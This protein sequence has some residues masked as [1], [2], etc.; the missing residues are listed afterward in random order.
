MRND[1]AADAL[2]PRRRS[3]RRSARD[4]K[5]IDVK[6]VPAS[7]PVDDNETDTVVI[8]VNETKEEKTPIVPEVK[9]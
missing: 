6:L 9:P 7:A 3:G 5:I 1:N 8:Y 4:N 2:T